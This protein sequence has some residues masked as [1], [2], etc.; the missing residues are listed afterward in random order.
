[1]SHF[2]IYMKLKYKLM[3]EYQMSE[4]DAI[5][6]LPEIFKAL[7]KGFSS[8]AE[9]WVSEYNKERSKFARLF[10]IEQSFRGGEQ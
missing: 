1:M 10:E 8:I 9:M 2:V 3:Y 6:F 5:T 7:F 4:S